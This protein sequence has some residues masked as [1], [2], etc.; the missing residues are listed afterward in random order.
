MIPFF[1]FSQE[2]VPRLSFSIMDL[3]LHPS[4]HGSPFIQHAAQK[5]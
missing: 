5:R 4:K 2:Q 3:P 1:L